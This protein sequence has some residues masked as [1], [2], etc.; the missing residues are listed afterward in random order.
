MKVLKIKTVLAFFILLFILN[1][2]VIS[3]TNEELEPVVVDGETVEYFQSEKKVI[4]TGNVIATY[5]DMKLTADK[6]TVYTDTKIV[7]AQ[8]NVVLKHKLGT[9]KAEK[10]EYNFTT[11]KATIIQPSMEEVGEWYGKAETGKKYNEDSYVLENGYITTCDLEKPHYRLQSKKVK[12]YLGDKIVARHVTLY[13]KNVPIM[14]FPYYSHPLNDNRPRVTIVPGHSSDWGYYLLT[15]WRYVLPSIGHGRIHLDQ[16]ELK[17]FASGFDLNYKKKFGEGKFKFYYTHEHDKVPPNN[18]PSDTWKERYRV[19]LKNRSDI[20]ENT[21]LLLELNK[22][23]DKNFIKDYFEPEYDKDHQPDSYI[24]LMHTA[25]KYNVTLDIQKRLNRFFT[26]TETLPELTFDLRKTKIKN[27]PLFFDNKIIFSNFSKKL[28]DSSTD[29]D[30][31]RF[32]T[33]NEISYPFRALNFLRLEPWTATRQTYYTKDENGDESL[34]RGIF[35]T[36]LNMSTKFYRI[37]DIN[38]DFLNLN[39]NK[40]RHIIT[41]TAEYKYI[42]HPTISSSRFYDFDFIDEISHSNILTLGLENRFQTKRET[43]DGELKPFDLGYFRTTIDYNFR[44]DSFGSK[45][46]N[47]K[48]DLEITPYKWLKLESDFEYTPETRDFETV[49]FD[50][51]LNKENYKFGVGHR[52]QKDTSSQITTQF[53]YYINK[54]K[55]WKKQWILDTYFRYEAKDKNWE[56]FQIKLTKDLHC[57]LVDFVYNYE[58]ET[59]NESGDNHT[60]FV[61]FRLKAFPEMAIQLFEAS[62]AEPKPE[63]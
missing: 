25:K 51:I 24:S 19:Q 21:L 15:A 58:E 46:E 12:V 49:N 52:Y 1:G 39:I 61:V 38:S 34:F 30:T 48:G 56:E 5:E 59:D 22:M 32:D 43:E 40:L 2:E 23:K 26:V 10:A 8:G 18:I 31:V 17:G 36:G 53:K 62:Y 16:R 4:A 54:G 3:K 42:H 9:F 14:Y 29:Y 11:D 55:D 50:T 37:F 6:A 63:S 57:W 44:H 33:Y 47:L 60:F 41:P 7:H 45:W 20:S 13:I 35:Y 27:T 28:A